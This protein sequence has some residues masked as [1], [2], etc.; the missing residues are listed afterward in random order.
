MTLVGSPSKSTFSFLFEG[1]L[2]VVGK[3]ERTGKF[4]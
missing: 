2:K 3:T 4:G 1:M